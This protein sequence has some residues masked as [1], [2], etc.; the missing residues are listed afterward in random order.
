MVEGTLRLLM[1]EEIRTAKSFLRM[2]KDSVRAGM[3]I[4]ASEILREMRETEHQELTLRCFSGTLI[5]SS[6]SK[7]QVLAHHS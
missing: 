4:P 5:V 1:A 2:A 6:A 3:S 7:K